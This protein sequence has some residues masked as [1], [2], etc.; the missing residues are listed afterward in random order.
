MSKYYSYLKFLNKL[1]NNR[2]TYDELFLLK[3]EAEKRT[4][5][6]N[7]FQNPNYDFKGETSFD[8]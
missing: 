2:L 5:S 4:K 8:L 1:H 7:N 3:K 6:L